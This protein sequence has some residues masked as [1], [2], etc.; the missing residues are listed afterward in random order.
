MHRKFPP[1]V[2]FIIILLFTGMACDTFSSESSTSAPDTGDTSVP[3]KAPDTAAPSTQGQAAIFESVEMMDDKSH[4]EPGT[5]IE[6]SSNPPSSGPHYPLT[7]NSGFYEE[8]Q[9]SEIPFPESYIVHNLEHGYVVFWYNCSQL[10]DSDCEELK[11][12]IRDVLSEVGGEKVI[13]FPWSN[14]EEV[15]VI[16]SWGMVLRFERFDAD[17]AGDFVLENRSNPRAP[18]PN[19]P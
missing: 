16:T 2:W 8:D 11:D 13:V 18:E 6:Y 10:S 5:E 17:M 12:Q 15:L 19:V 9:G 4:F 1:I 3:T 14:M 7:L